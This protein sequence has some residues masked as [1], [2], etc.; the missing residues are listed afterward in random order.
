MARRTTGIRQ[1]GGGDAVEVE[2]RLRRGGGGGRDGGGAV[3]ESLG[4]EG[5][6]EQAAEERFFLPRRE[7][8]T[9]GLTGQRGVDPSRAADPRERRHGRTE[10][11]S[12]LH[13]FLSIRDNQQQFRIVHFSNNNW[14]L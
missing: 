10:F 5:V 11:F 9:C 1:S 6:K 8:R 4:A 14:K 2:V 12:P 7:L 13:S 3:E